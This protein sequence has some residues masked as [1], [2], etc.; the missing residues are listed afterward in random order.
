MTMEAGTSP[1]TE[2]MSARNRS[3]GVCIEVGH[4]NIKRQGGRNAHRFRDGALKRNRA[5]RRLLQIHA[6][7]EYFD[8]AWSAYHQTLP[9]E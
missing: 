5:G 9:Y 4:F 2:T 8:P 1:T 6:G 3:E 7:N